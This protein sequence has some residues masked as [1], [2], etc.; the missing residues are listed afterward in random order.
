MD[1][2][3]LK[4]EIMELT[5]ERRTLLWHELRSIC[6]EG[7]DGNG[8]AQTQGYVA[9]GHEHDNALVHTHNTNELLLKFDSLQKEHA[10]SKSQ[11]LDLQQENELLLLQLHQVQEELEL[12]YLANQEMIAA[13]KKSR[14][15]MDQARKVFINL[16]KKVL[17]CQ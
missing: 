5:P 11:L 16:N 14:Q 8:K 12:Y 4:Q 13:L 17:A 10:A 15:S 9:Q 6:D 1:I 7:I 3:A 2:T